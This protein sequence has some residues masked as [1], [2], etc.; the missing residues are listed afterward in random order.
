MYSGFGGHGEF[1]VLE[2]VRADLLGRV[3]DLRCV[4]RVERR[5]GS[6]QFDGRAYSNRGGRDKCNN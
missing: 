6:C 5:C 4:V 3:E 1:I 2:E